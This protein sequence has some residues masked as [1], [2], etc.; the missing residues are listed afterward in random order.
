MTMPL[1]E[2]TKI[3]KRVGCGEGLAVGD[4]VLVGALV[5]LGAT[6][7]VCVINLS[8]GVVITLGEFVPAGIL[9]GVWVASL[10]GMLV[11]AGL[12]EKAGNVI[13]LRLSDPMTNVKL[14]ING[15]IASIHPV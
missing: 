3:E 7:L 2:S 1:L 6:V 9:V 11:G 4:N 13:P 14:R 15:K 10:I 5:K 8:V 12:N